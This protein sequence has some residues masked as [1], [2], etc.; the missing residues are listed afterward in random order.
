MNEFTAREAIERDEDP[1]AGL[2]SKC[3]VPEHKRF[4]W[5]CGQPVGRGGGSAAA[6]R[7]ACR[8]C[9]TRYSFG[10]DLA[11]GDLVAGQYEVRGCLAYGGVGWIY[12][13]RDRRVGGRPVVLKGLRNPGDLEAHIAA[14]AERQFLSEVVHPA[15]VKIFNFVT[16]HDASGAGRGYIVMEYVAG[17][18]LAGV[19]DQR[20]APLTPA[21]AISYLL[22]VLPALDYLHSLGL[23]YNDL[24]PDNIM[25]SPDEVKLIDL[26]AV[27]AVNS[28]GFLYGTPGFQ[29]PE[30]ART[31]PTVATDIYTIGRT[32]AAL[33]RPPGAPRDRIVD[34]E[35]P[36]FTKLLRRATH[37]D[38]AARFPSVRA[39]IGQLTGVLRMMVVRSADSDQPQLS[40]VFAEPRQSDFGVDLIL[41]TLRSAES[42]DGRP[43]LTAAAVAAA[44]P[45]PAA[46][47][48]LDESRGHRGGDWRFEW[49]AGLTALTSEAI[50][51]AQRRFEVVNAML[52]G[53]TAPL[54]ALAATAELLGDA[55]DPGDRD[56]WYDTAT[57]HYRAVWQSDRTIVS[58]GFGLARRLLAAGD[59][60]AAIATLRRV[61]V[62]SSAYDRARMTISL[63]LAAGPAA[64]L[65]QDRLEEA[66]ARLTDL[67]REARVLE[68]CSVV[69]DGAL[70]WVLA[71][72]RPQ[73]PT[74]T[75]L[76]CAYAEPDLRRGLE[77]ALRAVA[78]A[79][80]DTLARFALVDRANT[81]RPRSW[82]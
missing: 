73:R 58:A 30:I 18:S 25:V 45:V 11:A 31:G 69:L 76:G 37:S 35:Y 48:A 64:D 49:F 74:D 51:A 79:T 75:I 19:L 39:L 5:S 6:L 2:L 61:P 8:N 44:L 46:V 17:R 38:P 26:G 43:Q 57:E 62:R 33:T 1:E 15:I 14:L 21:E 80:P 36:A 29:A 71:G 72:G 70:H 20:G 10:P 63:L 12:L 32:L 82:Y 34:S 53:E 28:G 42:A 3:E 56:R 60:E 66:A 81:V 50:E 68:L 4:C 77:S 67:A 7:G 59:R 27:A 23:A 54:L 55:A 78:R 41:R 40:A 13:A 47:S 52:P 65:T 22:K 24:K 9:D 16:H